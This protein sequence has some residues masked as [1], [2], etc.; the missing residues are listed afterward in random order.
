M[1]AWMAIVSTILL[2]AGDSPR[3]AWVS[4]E[5]ADVLVEPEDSAFSTGQ[6]V[7]GKRVT[8][9]RDGPDGWVTI[10][11]PEDS[12]SFIEESELED[13]GDGRA[14]ILVKYAAVR[15]GRDGARMPGPPRVTLK[16]GEIVRLLD[17][18]PIALRD[19]ASVQTWI[20]I[21]PPLSRDSR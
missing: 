15:P 6:L 4:V 1:L 13:L 10:V 9:R 11:P 12:F 16:Q 2:T 20:P 21:A 17:R 19:G 3:V 8:V 18:R 5:S 14:R 7:R